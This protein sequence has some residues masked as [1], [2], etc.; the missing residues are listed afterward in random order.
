MHAGLIQE[1]RRQ[2]T[3]ETMLAR[4]PSQH[5]ECFDQG[6]SGHRGTGDQLLA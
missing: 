2:I 5:A 3:V 4:K 6:V 1:T